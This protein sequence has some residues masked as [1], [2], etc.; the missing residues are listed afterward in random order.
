MEWWNGGKERPE[1]LR[2]DVM[3]W[4]GGDGG[5]QPRIKYPQ[6][7][8]RVIPACEPGSS[9]LEMAVERC[10]KHTGQNE[11]SVN[12]CNPFH[13]YDAWHANLIRIDG[14]D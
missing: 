11:L 7:I 8:Y 5:R 2:G 1:G 13:P 3:A 14:F 12:P 4:W 10:H 6:S 9:L